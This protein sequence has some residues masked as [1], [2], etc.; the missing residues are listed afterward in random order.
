MADHRITEGLEVKD[1][2]HAGPSMH[3]RGYR[4]SRGAQPQM[5][6]EIAPAIA[7]FS[8]QYVVAAIHSTSEWCQSTVVE[9]LLPFCSD[10]S[11]NQQLIKNAL[12]K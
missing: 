2:S 6:V 11:V 8:C 3:L 4:R 7:N 10:L 5:A 12:T 1:E 9:R